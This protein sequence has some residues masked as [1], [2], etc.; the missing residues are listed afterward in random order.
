M[1]TVYVSQ[2]YHT[3]AVN[4]KNPRTNI[5]ILNI[6]S[7]LPLAFDDVVALLDEMLEEHLSSDGND[8]GGIVG[9]VADVLVGVYDLLHAGN[10]SLILASSCA[11]DVGRRTR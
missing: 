4:E 10:C 2:A 6:S 1:A 8:K 5:P 3:G 9:A 11:N 7:R